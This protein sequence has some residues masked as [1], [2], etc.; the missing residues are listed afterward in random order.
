MA[1]IE[2]QEV[3][4]AEPF[5]STRPASAWERWAP[6]AG[7]AAVVLFAV[8]VLI[9]AF[10]GPEPNEG[11]G[12][13]WLTYF[14][15]DGRKIYVSTLI[16]SLGVILFIWFLGRLR[17]S[18][19]AAEGEAGH[20]TTVAFGSGVATAVMLLAIVTPGLAGAFA[21]DALEPAAAQALGLAAFAFFI[22]AQVFAAVLLAATALAALRTAVLPAWLGWGSLVVAV[23]LLTPIGFIG[24]LIGFPLWV[25]IVSVLLWRRGERAVVARQ[26]PRPQVP[27]TS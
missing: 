2:R 18:L 24:L 21:S 17:V 5:L 13:E 26:T 19:L 10:G 14:R 23:L 7:I 8:G 6:L 25:L 9:G 22:G 11:T 16:F 1:W 20:W 15:E 12:Q 27:P 3:R 4:L